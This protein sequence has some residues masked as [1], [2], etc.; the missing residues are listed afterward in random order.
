M[1]P[2][3]KQKKN[4]KISDGWEIK[5]LGEV[6]DFWNGKGHEKDISER[7]FIVV[8]SKFVSSN[9]IVRKFSKKQISPLQKNDVVMVMS[10]VPKGKAIAK[11]FLIDRD[12]FYTLNQRIGGFK[13]KKIQSKFL[14]NLINRNNYF[15]QFDDGVNQTNLRKD[16]ILGCPLKFP[17]FSEQKRIIAVLGVWDEVLGKLGRKI[18]V[19]KNIKKGLMQNFLTGEIRVDG[20]S[21]K[22]EEKKLSDF[23][24]LIQGD[25]DWI[26]SKDIAE[27]GKYEVIQLGSIGFGEYINKKLKTI[28]SETFLNIGGKLIQSGDLLFNRMV[29]GD[30]VNVC[31]F[32]KDDDYITSVDI[33][34]LRK[35]KEF[36]NYYLLQLMLLQKSQNRFLVLSSGSGRVRISKKNLF[37]KFKFKLPSLE[38]QE[39]IVTILMA[40]DE[41]LAE[42]L[43]KQKL[44]EE[45]KKFLLNN[46]ISGEIRVSEN[47]KM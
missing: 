33:C 17:P 3:N 38:E 1:K 28:S 23:T 8:N 9:G 10:D 45:Q 34:W 26:L 14:Q 44:Y 25:G 43:R 35:S 6:V 27:N 12:N 31:L 24:D 37:E 30:K 20:F 40:A 15:L 11:T 36:L 42:L 47:M 5:K 39:A 46:L 2:K 41:E 21:E 16:D 19:K 13:S 29:N 4:K 32:E 7:G 22:W 18:E